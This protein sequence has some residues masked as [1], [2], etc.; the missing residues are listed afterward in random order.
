METRVLETGKGLVLWYESVHL[1]QT[2]LRSV[3][4]RCLWVSSSFSRTDK[5]Q[6]F[7]CHNTKS[8][9]LVHQDS[10]WYYKQLSFAG[11]RNTLG[12]V[13]SAD[14]PR[15]EDSRV[16]PCS[17][18][19]EKTCCRISDGTDLWPHLVFPA[20]WRCWELCGKPWCHCFCSWH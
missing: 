6:F 14:P 13:C 5:Q 8:V 12:V 2:V 16:F 4:K 18:E 10:C 19:W 9:K 3:L 11:C 15:H 20:T 17:W 7:I 1:Y